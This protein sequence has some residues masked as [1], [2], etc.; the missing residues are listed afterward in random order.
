MP[1]TP[2]DLNTTHLSSV[3]SGDIDAGSRDQLFAACQQELRA[4]ANRLMQNERKNHTLQPT[5]LVNEA[6]LR[7][8]RVENLSAESRAHFVNI[9]ARSM[10]QI[11][12]EHARHKNA[13]KRG[14][15]WQAVT[16]TGLS[17]PDT[18]DEIELLALND[19]LEKFAKLDP[20]GARVVDLRVFG[21]L[22][23]VEIGAVLNLSRRTVQKDWR[24][25]TM[26]LRKELAG[27]AADPS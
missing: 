9:A 14:G 13:A 24:F 27:P 19:A 17:G 18:G 21:G 12:V 16:L 11:L 3:I 23:M 10:R 7:L 20:R 25:A 1:D 26:W 6:Y 22:T 2:Q 4:I 15:G 8:F 5:A